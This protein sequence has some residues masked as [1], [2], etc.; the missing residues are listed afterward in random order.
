MRRKRLCQDPEV[1]QEEEAAHAEASEEASAVEEADTDRHIITIIT[2]P[3]YSFG[4]RDT[5]EA[6]ASADLSE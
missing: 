4:V 3:D 1:A 6:V 5:T 2:D